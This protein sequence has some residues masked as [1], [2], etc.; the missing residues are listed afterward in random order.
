MMKWIGRAIVLGLGAYLFMAAALAA[1]M[2]QPPAR[3]GQIMRFVPE[4]LVWGVLPGP[5]IWLWA[6]R[7][8]LAEGDRAPDFTLPTY[9]RKESV[10]LSSHRGPRPVVLVFGSYT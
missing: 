10:T 7:G 8:A 4:P 6:R 3:F 2:M 9:D 5:S 1:A